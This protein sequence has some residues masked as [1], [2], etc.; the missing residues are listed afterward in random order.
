MLF[1]GTFSAN[2][3]SVKIC[4]V[5]F[6]DDAVGDPGCS[7]TTVR[8]NRRLQ[9]HSCDLNLTRQQNKRSFGWFAPTPLIVS[10]VY[11]REIFSTGNGSTK[12]K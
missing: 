1:K 5:C 2:A 6:P 7:G 12:L 4:S 10:R 8:R 3:V 11:P 9:I